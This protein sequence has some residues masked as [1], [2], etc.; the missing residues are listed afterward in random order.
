MPGYAHPGPGSSPAPDP[1][2]TETA[3]LPH[4]EGPPL[5]RPYIPAVPV[6][7]VLVADDV[8]ST[9]VLPPVPPLLPPAQPSAPPREL[10]LFP[11]ATAPGPQG[12]RAA[13]RRA[14]HRR[15]GVGVAA[16]AGVVALGVG[17]ALALSPGSQTSHETLPVLPTSVPDPVPSPT[18][19]PQS[20]PTTAA[21]SSA[22]G[23]ASA[24]SARPTS[25]SPR[26]SATTVAPTTQAPAAPVPASTQAPRP[27]TAPATNSAP[28]TSA[29]PSTSAPASPSP[30]ATFRTLRYRMSG[31]DVAALQQQ[32][33]A[34]NCFSNSFTPGYF[35]KAT[36]YAVGNFQNNNMLWQS[37]WGVYDQQTADALNAGATC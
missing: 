6:T 19:P 16:G 9:T 30:S 1:D 34:A 14:K 12:G 31:A 7:D 28:P 32:L 37:T 24:T 17:L 20:A 5:V 25:A 33:S 8:F 35:D 2:V 3:V 18:G 21:A 27:S 36:E 11:I 15:R 23:S 13:S 10:G 26:S 4:L 22:A 29:A